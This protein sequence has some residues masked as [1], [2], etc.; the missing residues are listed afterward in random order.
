MKP[1]R[2]P[3]L[4]ATVAVATLLG[5][6][7][8]AADQKIFE[9][10]FDKQFLNAAWDIRNDSQDMRGL[11]DGRLA[12]VAQPGTLTKD[13]V[14]NFLV[15]KDSLVEKNAD[16][17]LKLRVDIQ[18]Y[19]GDWGTRAFGGI[20]LHRDKNTYLIL[21]ITN[22]RAGYNSDSGPYAIFAK[23][24]GGKTMPW[25]SKR[26]AAMKTGVFDFHLK[27][28]K[29]SYKYTASASPDG[30]KWTRIGTMAVLNTQLKPALF[31]SRG[32]KADEVIYEFDHFSISKAD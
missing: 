1:T 15:L 9:D 32:A 4:M 30:K 17:T 28:E 23:R 6:S 2:L 27:I 19:G 5:T 20:A 16:V 18:R 8:A 26:L 3:M 22:F 31:A 13:S 29:R 12:V 10:S 7:I 25:L 14:K 11:D 24:Q 21:Y